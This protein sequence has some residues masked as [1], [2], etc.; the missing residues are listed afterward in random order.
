MQACAPG[1][2]M[3]VEQTRGAYRDPPRP[4]RWI[5]MEGTPAKMLVE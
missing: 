2:H 4:A 5:Y 1:P 3:L